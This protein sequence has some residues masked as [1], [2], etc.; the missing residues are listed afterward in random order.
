M[1][2]D[3]SSFRD[4]LLNHFVHRKA[5][6]RAAC[7]HYL[8]CASCVAAVTLEQNGQPCNPEQLTWINSWLNGPGMPPHSMPN[9]SQEVMISEYLKWHASQHG[10]RIQ[11][12]EFVSGD[13]VY[14]V[15]DALMVNGFRRPNSPSRRT[16]PLPVCIQLLYR[17]PPLTDPHSLAAAMIQ[18]YGT[19]ISQWYRLRQFVSP[20][21]A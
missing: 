18:T 13:E 20:G 4:E 11:I 7:H 5:L 15:F 3:C 16:A 21:L 2:P 14:Q 8:A 19:A 17:T 6:S 1:S 9:V 12:A 10:P